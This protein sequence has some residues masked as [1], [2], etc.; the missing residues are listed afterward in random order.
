M[1]A[2]GEKRCHMKILFIVIPAHLFL[3]L[4][5]V[6]IYKSEGFGGGYTDLPL[7]QNRYRIEVR[8][9]GFTSKQRVQ[10]IAMVRAADL[11]LQNDFEYFY[12]LDSTSDERIRR[13]NVDSY[14]N[15]N[16]ITNDYFVMIIEMTH[17]TDG[18]SA[19]EII[20]AVGPRV[21]L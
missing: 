8:G 13:A 4:G 14:G 1:T 3:L 18:V 10:D 12:V 7:G 6:T 17:M 16:T 20:D 21:G 5:C 11:S 15:V 2:K 19:Q 9:N